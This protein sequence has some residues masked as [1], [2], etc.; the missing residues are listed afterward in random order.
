MSNNQLTRSVNYYLPTDLRNE[1]LYVVRG[2]DLIEQAHPDISPICNENKFWKDKLYYDYNIAQDS[3]LHDEIKNSY[4][5]YLLLTYTE[6]YYPDLIE[7]ILEKENKDEDEVD[8]LVDDILDYIWPSHC[9][10]RKVFDNFDIDAMDIFLRNIENGV[11]QLVDHIS[12]ELYFEKTHI[13]KYIWEKYPHYRIALGIILCIKIK[14]DYRIADIEGYISINHVAVNLTLD[15]LLSIMYAKH[16]GNAFM[17][18]DMLIRKT[19]EEKDRLDNANPKD[20]QLDKYILN[21][22]YSEYEIWW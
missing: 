4:E 5:L 21:L 1:Y 9:L 10:G 6:K 13:I 18:E 14:E 20:A 16:K 15:E 22:K 3:R 7:R 17:V 12:D 8:E 11:P 2:I 19:I